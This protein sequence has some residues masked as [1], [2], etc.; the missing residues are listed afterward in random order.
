MRFVALC[1][2][3]A[4]VSLVMSGCGGDG[5]ELTS[6][7]GEV[8]LDGSPLEGAVV[9]FNPTAEGG[10]PS[11]GTTDAGGAYEL[12]FTYDKKGAMPGDHSVRI[13]KMAPSTGEGE[14]EIEGEDVESL[15]ARY[16][17]ETT[18]T[19]TVESGG[20]SIDFALESG[21]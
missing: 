16:N 17:T 1:C 21:E 7:K 3:V 5:P 10:S 8:T 12:M 6:V 19:A 9:T 14:G 11:S 2:S 18:L 15:P 20:N 13:S 4:L